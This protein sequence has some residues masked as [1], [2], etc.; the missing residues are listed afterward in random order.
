MPVNLSLVVSPNRFD[1][2]DV[3]EIAKRVAA[4]EKS[5][6]INMVGPRDT[7]DRVDTSRWKYPSVTVAIGGSAGRFTPVRG[8]IFDGRPTPKLEQ[9]ARFVAGGIATPRT[10]KFEFG[11]AYPEEIWSEFVILKPLP[12]TMTSKSGLSRLYRSRRLQELSLA[13]LPADHFLRSGPALVQEFVDTGLYPFK[14]R[15]LSFL[16]APLYSSTTRSAAPRVEL[17]ASDEDIE[18]S[19]VDAKNPLSKQ[20]DP[21]GKR[22][23]LVTD[24]A[25]LDFARRVH[26]LFPRRSLLGID[27]LQREGDGKLFALEINAG[28]NVWHFS[29]PRE[30]HRNRLGGKEAMISQYGAWDVAARALVNLALTHAT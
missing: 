29:S 22:N 27:I 11:K 17:N 14:W 20:F 16:G 2:Q 12:L 28:G 5:I 26:E 1:V 19:I 8:P 9:F 10:E 24:E 18:A 3:A 7:A 13:T 15:V 4:A 25:V 30:G 6:L 23:R 21:E